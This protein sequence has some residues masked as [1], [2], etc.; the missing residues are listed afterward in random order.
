LVEQI[1]LPEDGDEDEA[2]EIQVPVCY[3]GRFA[4]DMQLLCK[5]KGLS[6][7]EVV[8]L[9]CSRIYRVYMLGFLP[10]FTYMGK[11]DERIAIERKERPRSEVPA[12]SVGI[13]GV[14]TGIYPMDSPGGWQIIGRTPLQLFTKQSEHPVLF[15]P[16]DR[17]KFYSISEN[18][19][20][21]HQSGNF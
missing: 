2:R 20:K 3:S 18:E 17:V 15:A 10:G 12:G 1:N 14:Q 21:D 19:F 11:V 16:G 4:P 13:A 5:Q 8:H 6:T 9:H 7:E